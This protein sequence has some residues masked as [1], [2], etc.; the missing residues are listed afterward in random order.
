M[1][2]AILYPSGPLQCSFGPIVAVLNGLSEVPA[3]KRML[4]QVVYGGLG[5]FQVVLF[6]LFIGFF[7]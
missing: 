4:C 7:Q 6:G 2:V 1:L 5:S 3:L